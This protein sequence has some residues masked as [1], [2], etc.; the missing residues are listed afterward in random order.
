MKRMADFAQLLRA[1]S[2]VL[3]CYRSC[4]RSVVPQWCAVE[5]ASP[6]RMEALTSRILGPNS[7]HAAPIVTRKE[8]QRYFL[9][10]IRLTSCRAEST[11]E[12]S[13]KTIIW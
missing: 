4:R 12:L 9:Q 10:L 8:S 2:L 3:K 6:I 13:E 11:C 7:I 1:S 5:G